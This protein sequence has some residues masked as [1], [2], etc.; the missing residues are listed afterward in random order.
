MLLKNLYKLFER[1]CQSHNASVFNL[2]LFIL[3]YFWDHLCVGSSLRFMGFSHLTHV[4]Q[5]PAKTR[6]TKL[7][8][9]VRYA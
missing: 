8:A 2:T 5:P 3:T 1:I 4:F 9:L 6:V 7:K